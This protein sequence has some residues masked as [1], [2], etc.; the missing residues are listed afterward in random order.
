MSRCTCCH[1][2]PCRYR[3]WDAKVWVKPKADI[4]W[5][6]E[7]NEKAPLP[8]RPKPV[9]VPDD[10]EDDDDDEGWSVP[11]APPAEIPTHEPAVPA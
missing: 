3:C 8:L 6:D 11:D 5:P 9:A 2:D 7:E 10:E 4:V 1:H